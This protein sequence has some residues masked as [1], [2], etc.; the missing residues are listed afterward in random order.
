MIA[1]YGKFQN[2]QFAGPINLCGA[3]MISRSPSCIDVANGLGVKYEPDATD[4]A[5]AQAQ[6]APAQAAGDGAPATA[7]PQIAPDDE[8][9]DGLDDADWQAAYDALE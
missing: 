3:S 9:D 1:I 8:F 6:Q 2:Q 4:R 7:D 5:L